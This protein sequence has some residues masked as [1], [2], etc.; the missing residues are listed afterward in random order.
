[1]SSFNESAESKFRAP[2]KLDQPHDSVSVHDVMKKSRIFD[3]CE[4]WFDFHRELRVEK[5]DM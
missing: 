5:Y 1:M 3:S 4:D 2:K